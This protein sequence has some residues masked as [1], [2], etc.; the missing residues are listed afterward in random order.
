[1]TVRKVV[2][3]G[4][5]CLAL[6]VSSRL[7]AQEPKLRATLKGHEGTVSCVAFSPDGKTLASGSMDSTVK[8]WDLASKKERASLEGHRRKV[9]SVAFSPDGQTLASSSR[10]RTIKLW[11]VA[12]GKSTNVFPGQRRD[13]S[14][15][16]FSPD[17]K[18]LAAGGHNPWVTLWD[19]A[20]GRISASL[21]GHAL[22]ARAVAFS[23]DGKTLASGSLDETI[24]LWEGITYQ[25]RAALE[26]QSACSLAF[27]P[28]SKTLASGG[29][30]SQAIKLWEVV[31]G[32]ERATLPGKE[33]VVFSLVFSPDG[34]TLA[35]AGRG[36]ENEV[37]TVT[38]WDVATG[39]QRA[40]LPGRSPEVLS[41]AVS[42]DGK[43][44]ASTA[45]DDILL[46][47]MPATKRAVTARPGT[48]TSRELDALWTGLANVDAHKA[49]QAIKSLEETPSQA[50][51]L[52][53]GRLRPASEPRNIQQITMWIADLDSNRFQVRKRAN[54]ELEKLGPPAESALRR[55]LAKQSSR[56][57]RQRVERLLAN[58]EQQHPPEWLRMMRSLEVLE[59]IGSPEAKRI[60][61]TLA[62]GVEGF[63]L[64]REARIS[65][66][67][68][69]RRALGK[70]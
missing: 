39:K 20:T 31:T 40:I 3:F 63:R 4:L 1:M 44:L 23:P 18:I 25:E 45:T 37:A 50:I 67:R 26:G 54:E 5:V 22:A 28:D 10:D 38:L 59:D 51:A 24:K 36:A 16:A 7:S 69:N 64:T 65:L 21:Q 68:L 15:I 47:D 55:K 61:E 33:G 58:I 34:R 17:G 41:V 19:V 57:V 29:E 42:P 35:S 53:Q 66:D 32:K 14:S 11:D 27:S 12:S 46:W 56:E 43:T 2:R 9:V 13:F 49:Y 62:N 60:L 8:L 52:L 6:A 70:S 48:L 30:G